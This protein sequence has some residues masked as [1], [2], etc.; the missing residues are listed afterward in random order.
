MRV[1]DKRRRTEQQQEFSE[2]NLL[3]GSSWI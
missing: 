2:F 3:L 1:E